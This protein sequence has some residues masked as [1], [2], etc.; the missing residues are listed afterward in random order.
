MKKLVQALVLGTL[1]LAGAAPQAAATEVAVV[2]ITYIIKNHGRYKQLRATITNQV[3]EIE[4]SLRA[5][6]KTLTEER[7][8]LEQYR[9]G[10]A[11]YRKHERKVAQM[12]SDLQVQ[13]TIKRREIADEDAQRLLQAYKEIASVITSVAERFKLGL[14]VNFDSSKLDPLNQKQLST[15]FRRFVIFQ[16]KRDITKHVL[17]ELTRR[18]QSASRTSAT[19]R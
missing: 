17:E 9:Q 4:A 3:K 18:Y 14:V 2:D 19:R 12:Y 6:F 1:I 8:K 10:T 16:N 11:E 13:R 5:Q 15:I 7:K